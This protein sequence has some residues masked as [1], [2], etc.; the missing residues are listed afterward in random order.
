MT[1]ST[2]LDALYASFVAD[3]SG[4][5]ATCRCLPCGLQHSHQ[6][7]CERGTI[8][9]KPVLAYWLFTHEEAA[10]A[11]GADMPFDLEHCER[12]DTIASAE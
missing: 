9:G 3:K 2:L 5:F 4:A 7:W 10:V 1:D 12:I 6:E 11:D 8:D